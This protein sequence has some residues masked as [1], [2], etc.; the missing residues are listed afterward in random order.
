M[1]RILRFV[2]IG[3]N[4]ITFADPLTVN[5]TTRFTHSLSTPIDPI[6][7][8]YSLN[9]FELISSGVASVVKPNCD[10]GCKAGSQPTSVRIKVSGPTDSSD[11]VKQ[12]IL[13]ALENMKRA[14]EAGIHTG[15]L[16]T[17][18]TEFVVDS[19]TSG[20]A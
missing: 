12:Q 16:P 18:A 14:V 17:M 10:D 13:D 2:A 5:R 6:A 1:Q 3:A 11:A 15:F 19:G 8:R 4:D 9:R 7:G 20:G